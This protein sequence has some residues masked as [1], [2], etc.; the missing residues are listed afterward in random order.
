M[1]M[2]IK[3]PYMPDIA[4]PYDHMWYV[5]GNA[6]RGSPIYD[7]CI[8]VTYRQAHIGTFI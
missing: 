5:Y 4:R 7:P 3:D 2:P 8:L 6:H 1:G